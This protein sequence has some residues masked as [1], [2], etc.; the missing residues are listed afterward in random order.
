MLDIIWTITMHLPTSTLLATGALALTAAAAPGKCSK[1][2]TVS[3]DQFKLH[4]KDFHFAGSN[5]Y[6]FPFNGVRRF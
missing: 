4:G 2:V 5:A 3:G 6:Y 1:F